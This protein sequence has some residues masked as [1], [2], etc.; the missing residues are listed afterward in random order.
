MM[1]LANMEGNKLP[2]ER[3]ASLK[4]FGI[5]RDTRLAPLSATMT[6][7]DLRQTLSHRLFRARTDRNAHSSSQLIDIVYSL[8]MY[9]SPGVSNGKAKGICNKRAPNPC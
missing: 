7:A 4:L 6:K 5:F 2:G 1:E 9:Y 3:L 8:C